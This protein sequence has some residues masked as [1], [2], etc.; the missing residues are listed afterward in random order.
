VLVPQLQFI[1][2]QQE[3]S[4]IASLFLNAVPTYAI[5][6]R[7]SNFIIY[8]IMDY[9][10]CG[11]LNN[12]KFVLLPFSYSNWLMY[13]PVEQWVYGCS[14][15]NGSYISY[16]EQQEASDTTFVLFTMQSHYISSYNQTVCE[17]HC[18]CFL[19]CNLIAFHPLTNS[20]RVTL[21]F[22]A[23]PCSLIAFHSMTNRKWVTLYFFLYH[24]FSLDFNQLPTGSEWHCIFSLL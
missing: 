1:N 17:W 5:Q 20:M 14:L 10:K 11:Y 22:S 3:V 12:R 2:D 16:L 19:L 7:V 15:E 9:T 23:L 21:H 18:I 8:W 24:A 4:D 6:Q 13:F